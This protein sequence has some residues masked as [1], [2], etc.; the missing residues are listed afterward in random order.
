MEIL[1]KE[2]SDFNMININQRRLPAE[3]EPQQAV[4]LSFPHE[5]KDWP[6]KYLAVQWAFIEFIRKIAEYERVILVT[7]S[8]NHFNRVE[9]M[10]KRAHVDLNH[11]DLLYIAT[12]RSWMRDSG[13]IVVVYPDGSKEALQFKFNGWAKYGNHRKD[14][15]VAE[16]VGNHLHLPV[17]KVSYNKKAVVLEGGAIDCNGRGTLIT[18]EECLLDSSIQVRNA[19][20]SKSDYENIF[21]EYF[22]VTNVIWLGQGIEGDDTHGHVDDICR[23]VNEDTVVAC[24]E[25]NQNDPNHFYLDANLKRLQSARLEDGRKLT[26][27]EIPMPSRLDFEDMRLPASYANFLLLNNAVLVPTFNDRNDYKAIGVISELFPKR[28]VVGISA[29]DLIW[30][31]GTLHCLS[32][33]IP[34]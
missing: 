30:G 22:G 3:W 11:I 16:A 15:K 21:K 4:L 25:K 8:E 32:H 33:E 6:G 31:L 10:L 34:A 14:Q 29:I 19:G 1:L 20:F 26:I 18:T 13:P 9:S 2:L 7:N 17:T 27:V 5:G 24:S 12:N 28:E 23:F